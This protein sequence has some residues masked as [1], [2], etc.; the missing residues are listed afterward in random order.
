LNAVQILVVEDDGIIAE[1]IREAL[2]DLG[3]AVPAVASSGPQALDLAAE[4]SPD[5]V[6]MDIRL[7]GHMD[8]IETADQMRA[9]FRVPVVYLTAHTDRL[10]RERAARTEPFG[11]LVKP[12]DERELQ[13]TIE[14]A[15]YKHRAEQKLRESEG[16]YATT[17]RSIGD[18]VIATDRQGRVTFLNPAAEALTGWHQHEACGKDLAEIFRIIDEQ[19]RQ[20]LDNPVAQAVQQGALV[21]M[22]NHT[23]LLARDG[24]ERPIDD[25][26]AL[27]VDDQDQI[28]GAVLVF[29][30]LTGHRQRETR[31][32][33]AQKLEA[34]GKLAGGVAHD[35][36]NL[37]TVVLGSCC[38]LQRKAIA[39]A[40]GRR[41]LDAIADSAER[42]TGLT[43]QL[44]AFGRKQF[45]VPVVLDLNHL[46]AG[47]AKMLRRLIGEPI[48]LVTTL[49]PALPSVKADPTQLQQVI[50][51][52]VVN[53]RDT[54]PEGGRLTLATALVELDETYARANPEV[55]PG[56]YA[57]LEVADTGCG[58][59]DKTRARI[60]EPF[61]TTK[62]VGQGS[63]LGL[64]TVYG[65]VEQSGGHIDVSS[66]LGQGTTF[67]IYFPEVP[68]E[69]PSAECPE[70]GA[71][72]PGGTETILLVEDADS[73]RDV[74][75]QFLEQRGFIVHQAHH[76][77]EALEL[78][79]RH[80]ER[81]HLLL[82]D[83][84]MPQMT[85]SALAQRLRSRQPELK[86][87]YLSGYPDDVLD[88][89]DVL[90]PGRAF[91]RKPFSADDLVRKVREVLDT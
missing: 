80:A 35:F 32:R 61:F 68:A 51:N 29:H 53:A 19:T 54:M 26:A 48:E 34:I 58:M 78:F 82:T 27:I 4:Q 40:E 56:R 91:L 2:Q 89:Q 45:L 74:T 87:L 79:E 69:R 59:D 63:G 6:L 60:F 39:D 57:L 72:R 52:L 5:L 75:A 55:R 85:G 83:V 65:I 43:R 36:N 11:Y 77:G 1:H 67:R 3:Y 66:A 24:T 30:D 8:G 28:T 18:A 22:A 33:E 46:V 31:L 71:E 84:I 13:A 38:L 81:I 64:A 20:P 70:G 49:S 23:L 21:D 76:G 42:A 15:L 16:R 88:G 73:V 14:M 12:F 86:V 90:G 10:Y 37:M 25:K 62:E 7:K 47:M 50:L 9:H 41:L 44:L 17:L